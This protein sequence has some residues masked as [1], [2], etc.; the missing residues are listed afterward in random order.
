MRPAAREMLDAVV[1]HYLSSGLRELRGERLYLVCAAAAGLMAG[2]AARTWEGAAAGGVG[3][4]AAA[5]Q[6]RRTRRRTGRA[7][8]TESVLRGLR[9]EILQGRMLASLWGAAG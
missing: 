1:E 8:C 3:D 9:G 6:A 5:P 7:A 2:A 4:A